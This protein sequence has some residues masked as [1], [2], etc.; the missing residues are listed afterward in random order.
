[1]KPRKIYWRAT[2]TEEE[3]RRVSKQPGLGKVLLPAALLIARL[4]RDSDSPISL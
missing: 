4:Q 3:T 1:M 2:S